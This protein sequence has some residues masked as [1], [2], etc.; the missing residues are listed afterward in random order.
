MSVRIDGVS[1]KS[2]A[3]KHKIKAGDTLVS[4]NNNSINDVLDY[5]FYVCYTMLSLELIDALGKPY[6]ATVKKGEYDDLGL[7]FDTYL[8]DKQHSCTNKCVFCF[9]DQMPK[10][11]RETLYFKD[12]DN[13][14]SFLFGNYITLT[15]MKSEEID[16]II[17]MHV[18][19][20]NISVHTTNPELRVKMMN[21]RFAG[22]VLGYINRLSDAGIKMNCQLVLCNGINDGD[23][24][25]R[26]LNDLSKLYPSVQTIAC[27][28]VGI[29]KHREGL[30]PLMPY[31]E[32]SAGSSIDIIEQFSAEFY[33]KNGT[34]L[35]FPADEF[36][37]KAK[38]E[39]PSSDYY[40]DFNQIEN[41]VGII[42]AQKEEFINALEDIESCD[43]KRNITVATGVDAKPFIE[44]LV[45]LLKK[46]WYNF[47]CNVIAVEN[48]FFGKTITVA[49]LV[50]GGDLIKQLS[51]VDLG[52]QLLLPSCMLRSEQDK[53]LDDVTLE[54]VQDALNIE[55]K[56]VGNDGYDIVDAFINK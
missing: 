47:N 54:D 13:R 51:D 27:V 28:P 37:I 46:K 42:A 24:L 35:A 19:P 25:K 12:D 43:I 16:R 55:I 2:I 20:I 29:T 11:M 4:I 50:T 21:N 45:Q 53:F 30:Y 52:E 39:I 38:R 6:T 40:E 36:F 17:K 9:V 23:E 31:D 44:H 14:L 8:I 10:G 7:C 26:T 48:D 32:E 41:G 18:S 34:R 15:N 5:D 49:G 56:L 3:E 33:K 22:E 1:K